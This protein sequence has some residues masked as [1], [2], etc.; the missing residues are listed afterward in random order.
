MR[1]LHL[2]DLIAMSAIRWRHTRYEYGHRR[3]S[4]VNE[5]YEALRNEKPASAGRTSQSDSQVLTIPSRAHCYPGNL[6][7]A[8]PLRGP[9]WLS[10]RIRMGHGSKVSERESGNG[11]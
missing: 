6:I 4:M 3:S 10:F 1:S 8:F 11:S 7:L 2:G 5:S 9:T